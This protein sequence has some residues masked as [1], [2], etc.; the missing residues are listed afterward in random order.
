VFLQV[1]L[2]KP[3][4]VPILISHH[5]FKIPNIIKHN[6]FIILISLSL[7]LSLFL[8]LSHTHEFNWICYFVLNSLLTCLYALT[9]LFL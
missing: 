5:S 4:N 8:S 2:L 6:Q 9:H 3:K 1:P 7:S